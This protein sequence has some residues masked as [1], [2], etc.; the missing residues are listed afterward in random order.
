MDVQQMILDEIRELKSDVKEWNKANCASH[1]KFNERISTL[2]V[3]GAEGSTK[4]SIL[5]VVFTTIVM[6]V[7]NY[8]ANK[9][10]GI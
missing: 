10:K 5:M 6:S 2:E 3:K 8:F 9:F 7:I 1:D 4:L